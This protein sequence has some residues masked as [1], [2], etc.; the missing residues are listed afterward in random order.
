MTVLKSGSCDRRPCSAHLYDSNVEVDAW[1]MFVE[2]DAL[3]RRPNRRNPSTERQRT[4]RPYR[5]IPFGSIEYLMVLC[6]R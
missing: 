1:D 6:L 3:E 4:P 2:A 5:M